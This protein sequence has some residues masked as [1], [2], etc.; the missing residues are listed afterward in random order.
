MGE[1]G[2]IDRAIET[3]EEIAATPTSRTARCGSRARDFGDEK[4][5]VIVRDNG[6]KT[7]FASDIAYRLNKRERGFEHLMYIWGADHHGYITR[8]R[9]VL[10]ALGGPPERF[11][12]LLMQFV[13]LFRGGEKS[14]DVEALGR[15]SSP[16]A[17]CAR[18]SATMPPGCST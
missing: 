5:R 6:L 13:S 7:Y 12:V 3:P 10:I 18:R 17:T 16:C 4:D 11:E 9:A 2:A 8:L 14:Q 15:L 1:S